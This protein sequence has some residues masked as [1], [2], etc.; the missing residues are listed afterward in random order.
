MRYDTLNSNFDD[1]FLHLW[2]YIRARQ[3]RNTWK[4]LN[5]AKTEAQMRAQNK[6]I[7]KAYYR[8]SICLRREYE[9]DIR[10]RAD[11]LNMSM[12]EYIQTL[13]KKDLESHIL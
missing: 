13:I 11:E 2:Y 4:G 7:S 12:S 5:M 1:S 6:W 9:D 10:N 3:K 8:P